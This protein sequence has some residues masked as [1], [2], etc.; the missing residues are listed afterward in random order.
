MNDCEDWS[1]RLVGPCGENVER[2][3]RVE[4]CYNRVWGTVCDYNWDEVDANVIC[5]QLGYNGE[6]GEYKDIA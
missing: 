1:V 4:V 3:G 6:T 5:T 2:E